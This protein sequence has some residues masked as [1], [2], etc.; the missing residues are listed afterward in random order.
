MS[1]ESLSPNPRGHIITKED[2]SRGGKKHSPDRWVNSIKNRKKC[3]TK[4]AI[5][6]ICPLMALS[7]SK[8][9]VGTACLL[10]KGGNALIR[11]FVN[12]FV[13][14]E[15]GLLNELDNVLYIYGL[16]IESQPKSV[17]KEYANLI[18]QKHRQVYGDK[19]R[20]QEMKPQLTVVINEMGRDREIIPV[21]EAGPIRLGREVN[22]V[23]AEYVETHR[24]RFMDVEED[25]LLNSPI[26]EDILAGRIDVPKSNRRP[27]DDEPARSEG[28][29]EELA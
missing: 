5:F 29:S 28:E 22:E 3:S 16:D 13:K 7:I 20:I 15:Q 25:S 21:L 24:D 6:D 26:I 1:N 19:E 12:I 11:R 4:C 8:A 18:L 27:E 17:Q 10:N 2:S 9:N 14:G 23:M